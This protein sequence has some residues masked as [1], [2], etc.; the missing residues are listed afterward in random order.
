MRSRSLLLLPALLATFLV[1]AS[2]PAQ[3]QAGS[4]EAETVMRSCGAEHDTRYDPPSG[5]GLAA[6]QD[7]NGNHDDSLEY[8]A[9]HWT[10]DVQCGTDDELASG[11]HDATGLAVS[12]NGGQEGTGGAGYLQVCSDGDLPLQGRVTLEGTGGA[13]GVDGTITADGDKDNTPAETQGWA[14][15][16]VGE[17]GVACGKAYE[18]GG[19]SDAHHQAEGDGGQEHCG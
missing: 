17:P 5:E 6:C 11:G 8:E 15:A 1:A 2:P 10:N 12:G 3:D 9:T 7:A 4:S 13:D 18:E 14:Q 19:R 16:D